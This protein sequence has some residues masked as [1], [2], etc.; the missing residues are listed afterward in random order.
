MTALGPVLFTFFTDHL[1]MQK[2]LRPASVHSYRDTLKLFLQFVACELRQPVSRL[3]LEVLESDRVLAFLR[4]LEQQRHNHVRSRN[5][6]L[7]ALR[8]FYRFVASR[9]PTMLLHAERVERIAIKRA[10]VSETHCFDHEQIKRL[11]AHLSASSTFAQRDRA[12]LMLLYNTGARVQEVADLRVCDVDLREPLRVR[13]HGKGDKWRTCPLW[14]ETAALLREL[15]SVRVQVPDR[16]LFASR[17]QRPLTRFGIYKLVKRHCAVLVATRDPPMRI[18][19]H[20]FRHTTA[21]HLLE[22]GVDVNVIRGWLGHVSLTTT[23]RYAEISLRMKQTAVA[24]CL[25]PVDPSAASRSRVHW[26]QDQD[27]LKWLQTL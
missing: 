5:Q 11:F 2:G 6:R 1:Q 21:V 10:P 15:D 14:P 16:P 23:Y 25:P 3:S 4:D 12:L 9:H 20:V 17:L 8:T 18:S 22:A 19:P 26:R 27:L 24:L 13:L 7:A